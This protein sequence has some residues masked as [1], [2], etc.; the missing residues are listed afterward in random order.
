[1][2]QDT[3][4]TDA[5]TTT[6]GNASTD[7]TGAAAAP[8]TK[9]TATTAPDASTQQ[10]ATDA[11]TTDAAKAEG[12]ESDGDQAKPQGAPEKYEFALPDG[13]QMDDAG[14]VAFSEVA[15]DLD[16]SQEAAQKMLDKMA[17]AMAARQAEAIEQVR[18]EWAEG[19]RGDKEFGGDKLNENLATAK[20]A[21]DTF[22]TPEL[23][24]LL[25]ETGLGNHP[26]I[27]RAFFRAG[28]AISEDRFVAASN[29]GPAGSRDYAKSLYPNQTH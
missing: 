25:N 27:I 18:S 28:K 7:A 15:K 3:L 19:S 16:L 12:G 24:T 22:G 20:K 5:A 1:M 21:L 14:L 17:P 11:Q 29:G 4:M 10:K 9:S 23:R 13:V 26:E 8:A 6:E 2:T